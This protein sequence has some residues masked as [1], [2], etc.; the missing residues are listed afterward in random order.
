M[1]LIQ[2]TYGNLQKI[3]SDRV[4]RIPHYQRFY[5]WK[6][7]Q[8]DQLFED[9]SKLYD[10]PAGSTHF[11]ATIVCYQTDQTHSSYGTEYRISDLV[12]GQQRIT[13]LIILLKC[14]ELAFDESEEFRKKI[15]SI[16][17]KSDSQLLL[18]QSNN[19]NEK[20]F[21]DFVRHGSAPPKRELLTSSDENISDAIKESNKFIDEWRSL[22][23]SLADL[24]KLIFTK[25]HF[26]V[27]D[28]QDEKS[29]YT[30]FEV[31]N[32][33]GLAVDWLDKTKS[34]LMGLVFEH[35]PQNVAPQRI[36]SLQKIWSEIYTALARRET[37]GEEI[38]KI[39]ATLEYGPVGGKP[40]S[41]EEA[42]E[43]IRDDCKD[44]NKPEI[45]STKL[46]S[47]TRS[48][49]DLRNDPRI[50]V[51]TDIQQARI[52]GVAILTSKFPHEDQNKFLDQWE[53][54]TFRI[55]GLCGKD[56]R[57]QVG[58]YCRLAHE[59]IQ[60]GS[61]QSA[62][63]VLQ[64]IKNLA[65][66]LYSVEEAI[67]NNLQG[68]S[69]YEIDADVCR[70]ILWEYEKHLHEQSNV[71]EPIDPDLS[72]TVWKLSAQQTIEHIFPQSP[73]A[74]SEWHYK[75]EEWAE[76]RRGKK[77]IATDANGS[78]QFHV[79]R[80]GNLILL[81]DVTNKEASRKSFPDKRRIYQKSAL[82]M[83]AEITRE[84]DWDFKEIE[85]RENKLIEWAKR[86]WSDT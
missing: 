18:L 32:S 44:L 70:Y 64:K 6:K 45:I 80:I 42:L 3:V 35:A 67:N 34:M 83:V 5:S 10:Q 27:H 37:A 7:R 52:L 2:P 23:R 59:I 75:F 26:V 13:S 40:P 19:A 71:K 86:R 78:V 81:P 47:Y 49:T 11:M 69:I 38:L 74:N 50:S 1:T 62:L 31:L 29:V 21:N 24:F 39:M 25:L 16:L 55:F 63:D 9:I 76:R 51:V 28:T 66:G 14:I 82:K 54:S 61:K 73:A 85:A 68:R 53:R 43:A 4:F 17:I 12:D 77:R 20:L 46:L 48:L 72:R 36:A 56:A 84:R 15:N 60:Y 65:G 30:V 33:R 22:D 41:A 57:Y 79:H 8:R 58:E